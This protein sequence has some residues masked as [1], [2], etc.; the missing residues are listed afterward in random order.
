M[1]VAAV[2]IKRTRGVHAGKALAYDYGPGRAM[3]HHRPR[4]V[5]GTVAGRDWRARARTMQAKIRDD[6][7]NVSGKRG[8]V[9]R[10]AVAAAP[11]D[12][13][14]SDRDWS[15]IARRVVGEFTGNADGYAWEAVRHD[16]RH[17]HI[18]LLQRGHD[19]RLLSESHDYRR[20]GRI[21]DGIERDYELTRLERGAKRSRAATRTTERAAP[22]RQPPRRR[23]TSAPTRASA[24]AS[25]D[26]R[27]AAALEEAQ[28]RDQARQQRRARDARERG[29]REQ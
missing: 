29:G 24:A 3:E 1:G 25:R 11:E 13:V 18:T 5:A 9:I 20:F 7:D 15:T 17:I 12:R 23:E 28:R 6:G 26:E 14:L 2:I 10:L 8:R 22:N 21:S 19:G 27:M 4:R 16:P